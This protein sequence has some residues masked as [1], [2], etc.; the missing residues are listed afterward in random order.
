MVGVARLGE[1]AAVETERV[2]YGAD[3][4]V[5]P[6]VARLGAGPL[7]V[8]AVS[9]GPGAFTGLR[10]GLAHALGYALARGVP[11]VALSSLAVRAL[12]APG[13]PRVR[14]LLDAKKGRVYTAV[15]DTTGPVPRLVE[16]EVD[17]APDFVAAGDVAVGEGVLA[18][19]ERLGGFTFVA[20]PDRLPLEWAAALVGEGE[21]V[22]PARIGPRYLRDADARLPS[23]AADA[24]GGSQKLTFPSPR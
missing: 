11:M 20:E 18:H 1:G 8:V 5:S 15:Y 10:V 14:P 4:W 9:V 12:L 21:R 23:G 7:D 13:R 16:A 19:R 2:T 24:R 22:D 3:A 6:R 17:V